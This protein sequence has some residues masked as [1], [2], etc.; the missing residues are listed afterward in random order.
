MAGPIGVLV[1]LLIVVL[2]LVVAW[3]L[4][5]LVPGVPQ[6]VKTI[7]YV[8]ILLLV[9]LYFFGGFLNAVPWPGRWR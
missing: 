9:L 2:I 4:I 3:W 1:S 5:G 6:N 8:I 7:V